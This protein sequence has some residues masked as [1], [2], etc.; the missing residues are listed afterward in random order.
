MDIF[1]VIYI[2]SI[3]TLFGKVSSLNRKSKIQNEIMRK[4]V[5][6]QDADYLFHLAK[7]DDN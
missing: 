6:Q 4:Y 3:I 2:T 5:E 7:E 1:D